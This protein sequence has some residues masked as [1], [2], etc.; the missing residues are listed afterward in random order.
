[1]RYHISL[2]LWLF[3]LLLLLEFFNQILCFAENTDQLFIFDHLSDRFILFFVLL[4][5]FLLNL[6][7]LSLSPCIIFIFFISEFFKLQVILLQNCIIF[8]FSL[9]EFLFFFFK[10]NLQIFNIFW[11]FFQNQKHVFHFFVIVLAQT[12]S[13][14]SILKALLCL[15]SGN[16]YPFYRFLLRLFFFHD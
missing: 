5:Q 6:F 4:L 12:L 8:F 9:A 3:S 11:E 7:F 1:M 10:T 16:N 13:L 14:N 15:F 2:Y